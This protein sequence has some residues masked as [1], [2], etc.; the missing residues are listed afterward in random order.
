MREIKFRAYAVEDLISSQ[1]IE[2]GYGITKIKYT[3]GTSSVYIL[4]PYGDYQVEEESVGQY[5]G[6]KDKHGKE[7]FEGDIVNFKYGIGVIKYDV[8]AFNIGEGWNLKNLLYSVEVIGNI[9]D[10]AQLL[11]GK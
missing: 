1:W 10:N 6:L 9:H 7:I 5:T 11:E 2:D 3:D 8:C 4:T